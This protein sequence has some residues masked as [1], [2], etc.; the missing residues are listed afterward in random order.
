[1]IV[2]EIIITPI[3]AANQIPDFI[4]GQRLVVGVALDQLRPAWL[5]AGVGDHGG[6]AIFGGRGLGIPPMATW[7]MIAV[8][9]GWIVGWTALGAWKMVR[10]DA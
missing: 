9:V 7:A 5:A 2:L 10:R 1:M 3:L 4:N 6:R 8:I